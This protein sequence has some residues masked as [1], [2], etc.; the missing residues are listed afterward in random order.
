MCAKWR[1]RSCSR[2]LASELVGTCVLAQG[3]G[4]GRA[5]HHS[6]HPEQLPGE[7]LACMNISVSWAV[8]TY[9]VSVLEESKTGAQALELEFSTGILQ[10]FLKNSIFW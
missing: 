6:G 2:R 8:C 5:L 7:V 4:A 10:H 9:S 1:V 3:S